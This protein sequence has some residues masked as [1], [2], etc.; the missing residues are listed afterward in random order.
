[1]INAV[2]NRKITDNRI[3]ARIL[4]EASPFGKVGEWRGKGILTLQGYILPH[5]Q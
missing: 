4:E 2:E 1:V 3:I 5:R